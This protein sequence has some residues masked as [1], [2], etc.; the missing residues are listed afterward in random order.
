[1]NSIDYKNALLKELAD[2]YSLTIETLALFEKMGLV[3]PVPSEYQK[4]LF[5]SF[6]RLRIKFII[7]AKSHGL[8]F[9]EILNLIGKVSPVAD[10]PT[11]I[12]ESLKFGEKNA[13]QLRRQIK[14]SSPLE[15]VN[16]SCDL[17]LL[18]SYIKNVKA[19]LT[20]EKKNS[21]PAPAFNPHPPEPKTVNSPKLPFRT[22]TMH[23]E[24]LDEEGPPAIKKSGWRRFSFALC[25]IV[26]L[27]LPFQLNTGDFKLLWE[28]GKLWYFSFFQRV[29]YSSSTSLPMLPSS[30]GLAYES[31]GDKK[32]ESETLSEEDLRIPGAPRQK[33]ENQSYPSAIPNSTSLEPITTKAPAMG[34]RMNFKNEES[35]LGGIQRRIPVP[36]QKFIIQCELDST[37]IADQNG[38]TLDVIAEFVK[39]YPG[40]RLIIRGYT[41]SQGDSNYN[42]T[43]SALRAR[44][45]KRLMVSKGVDP[46]NIK[47][48][49]MGS[50]NPIGNNQTPQGRRMNRRIEIELVPDAMQ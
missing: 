18:Q 13:T 29:G 37:A 35:Y 27:W 25:V 4:P 43:L 14:K 3:W 23:N 32:Q 41:D 10:K 34:A 8:S 31:S 16:K 2:E 19:I 9:A 49:G 20:Q 36:T 30:P 5:N 50:A 11:Q 1:M 22:G 12:L 42:M 38:E 26:F 46:L 28:K 45:G 24:T 17:I 15:K 40:T 33:L 21:L 48:I 39:L 47:T 7:D 44:Q 6:T